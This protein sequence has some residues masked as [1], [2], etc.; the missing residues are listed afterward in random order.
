MSEEKLLSTAE[1]MKRLN[2][3]RGT[4]FKRLRDKKIRAANYNPALEKQHKPLYRESDIEKLAVAK[5]DE[6]PSLV[7]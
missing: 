6:N 2:I 4:F 7:A 3:S 1:A 5:S